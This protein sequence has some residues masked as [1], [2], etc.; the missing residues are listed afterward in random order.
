[1]NKLKTLNNIFLLYKDGFSNL[2]VGK[3]LWKLIIIKLLVILVFLNFFIYDRNL[4]T[5][6]K[7]DDKKIEF[8]LNNLIKDE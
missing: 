5:E 6:Y 4:N 8:I 2:R 7:T 3:T 1:M